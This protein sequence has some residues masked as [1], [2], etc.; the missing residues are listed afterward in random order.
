M[1]YLERQLQRLMANGEG[2]SPMARSLRE[3][4]AA[5]ER[6]ESAQDMYITGMMKR[7]PGQM[8]EGQ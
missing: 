8:R 6:G 7:Q 5:R 3:Q 4:I 1:D 2:K